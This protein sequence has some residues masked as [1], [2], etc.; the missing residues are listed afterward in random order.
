MATAITRQKPT[1]LSKAQENSCLSF[2]TKALT[3][4]ALRR[5]AAVSKEALELA[6]R[7]LLPFD[8][9]DVQAATVEIGFTPREEGETAWP[10]T[11][12]LVGLVRRKARLRRDE[13]EARQHA[14]DERT[15]AEE[16]RLHP[17]LFINLADLMA[18]ALERVRLKR[19]HRPDLVKPIGG[20]E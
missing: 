14:A 4:M 12:T 20:A 17:E 1:A 10:D 2:R 16:R 19:E 13:A 6:A 11:G 15:M 8:D 18:E 9:C 7:D 3:L 5:G